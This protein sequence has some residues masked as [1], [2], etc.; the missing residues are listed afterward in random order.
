MANSKDQNKIFMEG[1]LGDSQQATVNHE[2]I[3]KM[4]PS[5]GQPHRVHDSN[6]DEHQG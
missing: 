6:E 2:D 4:S 1:L 5:I 3:L